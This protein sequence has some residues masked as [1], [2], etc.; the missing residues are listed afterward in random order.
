MSDIN[1]LI[2][3]KLKKYPPPVN[4]ICSDIIEKA[5]KMP[6]QALMEYLDRMITKAVSKEEA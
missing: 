2:V 3:E 5:N 4:N 6:Q 1:D